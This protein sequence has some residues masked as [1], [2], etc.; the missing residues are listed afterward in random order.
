MKKKAISRK[1][2]ITYLSMLPLLW[3]L[4]WTVLYPTINSIA[5]SFGM[6]QGGF[7]LEYFRQFFTNEKNIEAYRNSFVLAGLTVLICGAI[8]TSFAFLITR[9]RFRG[10]KVF[11]IILLVPMMIPGVLF[12]LAF[13]Q[14]YG[15]TGFIPQIIKS[16]YG[17]KNAPDI[18]TG[19]PGILFVHATTQYLFFYVMI[20]SALARIDVSTY[21]AARSMGA[22]RARMFFTITLPLLTPAIVGASVLTFMSGIGSFAAPSLLGGSFRTMSVQISLTKVNGHYNLVAVQGIM[23]AMMSLIFLLVMR[24]YET[25]RNYTM[26]VKGKPLAPHVVRGFWKN[27][28]LIVS[29]SLVLLVVVLPILSIFLLSFVPK[30]AL[31]VSIF[32]QTFD[33][34]NYAE[35]FSNKRVFKPFLNSLWMSAAGAGAATIIGALSAYITVKTKVRVRYLV[36]LLVLIPWALPASTVA[37]NMIMGFNQ[38]TPF[39]FGHVL[40]G[41]SIL[42]PL[43][44]AVSRITIVMRN[45]SAALYQ[46]HDSIEEASRSLGANWIKTFCRIMVPILAPAILSGTML[47]FVALIGEYTMSILM[48]NTSTLPVTVAMTNALN[49]FNPG[50]AMVYGVFLVIITTTIISVFKGRN[51]QFRF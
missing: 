7:T 51:G 27:A 12:T 19:L 32:P 9:L 17:L 3:F 36:E 48:Y 25:R 45:T 4:G 44:Y 42:L 49:Q 46:L 31:A 38:P 50:L 14:M 13:M 15:R 5:I 24:F 21:E 22:S 2:L 29:L 30:R 10:R 40:V 6:D 39:A 18:L 23:L 47:G 20:S 33:L 37:V 43:T 1:K 41:S 11:E 8:G 28:L 26:D 16:L 34:S 35:F